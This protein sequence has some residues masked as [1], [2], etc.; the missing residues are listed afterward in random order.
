MIE[1]VLKT[2]NE[3]K[4]FNKNDKVIVAVSG[5]PDSISLLH[6]LHSLRKQLKIEIYAAHV[7]HCLRGYEADAD[8]EYVRQFCK[9]LNI[10][11]RSKSLDINKIA[12]VKNIS[13]ESAGREA[14]Y[15]FFETLKKELGAQKI[16]VAHNAN[17]QAETVLMRIMRGTGLEGLVGI[18]P[19]RDNV[20]VRP[21]IN[22]MRQEIEE[23]CYKENL[24]PRIDKT[25]LE[26]IYARNKVRLELIPYIEKNFN[27]DITN[28]LNRLSNII[29]V[30]ND[31]LETITKEKFKNYCDI[32]EEKVIISK[33]AF[34]EN[35]AI[36]NRIIRMALLK[37]SGNLN[38]F[39]KVHIYDITNMQSKSTGKKI[40]LPNNISVF[41]NYGDI[42]ICK[43]VEENKNKDVQQCLLH[44]GTNNLSG[45]NCKVT[46]RAIGK[47]EKV[48]FKH[49][50]LIKYFDCDE[51]LCKDRI[52]I[53]YRKDGDKFVPL[54]MKGRKKLKDFL[55]DEKISK[56]KR[57][58]IPLICFGDEIAWVVG[59][60]VSEIF[61]ISENTK[62][63]LEIKIEG[64]E[65]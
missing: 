32:E 38:N 37:I 42:F 1:T 18:K 39:E 6:V 51:I 62:N 52:S 8:E 24:N 46:L 43:K 41:N 21:L 58:S 27:K 12:K 44:T 2:I 64:E 25:N 35:E 23:Y 22:I 11:F 30:D 53:R 4:M 63:I 47:D 59:Y 14:R 7:N 45:Y 16:A 50:K 54:G 10:E 13:C 55:I 26:T 28:V 9:S 65:T 5:G 19:V 56:E 48:E 31:Y 3:Y 29:K 15:D 57:A 34:L 20:F 33:E 17:D 61:K 60:R 36:T 49:N 40:T